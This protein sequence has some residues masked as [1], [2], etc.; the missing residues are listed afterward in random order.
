MVENREKALKIITSQ[1]HFQISHSGI[2]KMGFDYY[3]F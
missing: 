2:F 3:M 1:M